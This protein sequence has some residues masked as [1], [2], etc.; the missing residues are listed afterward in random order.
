MSISSEKLQRGG[1]SEQGESLQAELLKLNERLNYQI[2]EAEIER[3]AT[4]ID[5]I[6]AKIQIQKVSTT[7][8]TSKV[9]PRKSSRERK[10]TPKMQELKQQEISQREN[11]FAMLYDKWKELIRAT[12]SSLK[13]ECSERDLCHMMDEVEGLEAQVKDVYENIRLQT[14]PSTDLRRKMDSCSAVT[15]DV[16]ALLKVRMSEEGGKMTLMLR[17]RMQ[18]CTWC[19]TKSMLNQYLAPQ[20]PILLFVAI[21][22]DVHQSSKVSRQR[23]RTVLHNWL[24]EKSRN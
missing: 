18:D 24:P 22:R 12:R 8:P 5:D 13:N 10:L 6:H 15:V 16:M 2:D 9:E 20:T 17:Q 3:L 11:K 4:L 7:E 21:S 1:P 19:L 23:E 14:A